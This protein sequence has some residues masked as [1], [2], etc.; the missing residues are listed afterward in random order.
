MDPLA[1]A[2]LILLGGEVALAIA[3]GRLWED[4]KKL[5][6]AAAPPA[7]QQ[8]GDPR[9]ETTHDDTRPAASHR[10]GEVLHPLP[11]LSSPA[12]AKRDLEQRFAQRA[13]EREEIRR[14][15]EA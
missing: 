10:E 5:R 15:A 14:R 4:V 8:T 12:R 13:R 2:V 7:G 1:L 9:L 11:R 3:A 6:G